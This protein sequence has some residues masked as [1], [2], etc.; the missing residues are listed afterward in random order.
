MKTVLRRILPKPLEFLLKELLLLSNSIAL[1]TAGTSSSVLVVVGVFCILLC[2]GFFLAALLLRLHLEAGIV[3]GSIL[4]SLVFTECL[5][6]DP[7]P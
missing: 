7:M 1:L 5:Y 4:R 3:S 2:L 6:S